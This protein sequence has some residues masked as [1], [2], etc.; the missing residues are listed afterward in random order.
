MD[1]LEVALTRSDNSLGEG[2]KRDSNMIQ[3]I[4]N[5]LIGRKVVSLKEMDNTEE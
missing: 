1:I 5:W 2:S 3:S 4:L